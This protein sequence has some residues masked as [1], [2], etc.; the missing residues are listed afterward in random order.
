MENT[1]HRAK[2]I[3]LDINIPSIKEHE[4]NIYIL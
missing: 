2:Y 1:Y 3:S 4:S